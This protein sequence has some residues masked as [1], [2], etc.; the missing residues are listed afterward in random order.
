M[1]YV[2]PLCFLE[3]S[4][5]FFSYLILKSLKVFKNFWTSSS[6]VIYIFFLLQTFSVKFTCLAL[7]TPGRN[8][9]ARKKHL[10]LSLVTFIGIDS[11]WDEIK[12]L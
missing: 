4:I 5:V 8:N 11:K 3:M 10:P 12:A 1:E 2:G 6:Q 9:S 7:R